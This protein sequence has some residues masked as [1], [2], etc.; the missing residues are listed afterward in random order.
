MF[1]ILL[2]ANGMRS[3]LFYGFVREMAACCYRSEKC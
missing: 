2:M 1:Y 3:E